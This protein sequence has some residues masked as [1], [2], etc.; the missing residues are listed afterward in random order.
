M[1]NLLT[2]YS[3][4][5]EKFE[6]TK[7]NFRD[8]T[9][10]RGWSAKP[11]VTTAPAAAPE[12]APEPQSEPEP[13]IE[14]ETEEDADAGNDGAGSESSDANEGEATETAEAGEEGDEGEAGEED[15]VSEDAEAF[16][17]FT[18]VEQFDGLADKLDVQAYLTQHFPD[19][20]FDGRANRDKLIAQ[21]IELATA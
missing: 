8:L 13:V 10:H 20:K 14:P 9:T 5:G 17:P 16:V 1:S 7:P 4:D 12:P 2:I 18:T 19:F 3:P 6:V 11:P 21:A 15:E